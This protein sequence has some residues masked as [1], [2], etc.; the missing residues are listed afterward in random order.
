[1]RILLAD[2]EFNVR[3]ALRT[4]LERQPGLEIVGE[5][6]RSG[7]LLSQ[8]K[9]TCPDLVLLDWSLRGSAA[10]DA[11]F[12]LRKVW[13]DLAVIVLSGRPEARQ[14]ALSAGADAFI[15]KTDPPEELLAAIRSVKR[16]KADKS[17]EPE[18]STRYQAMGGKAT[19]N[20]AITDDR[21]HNQTS[22]EREV[23]QMSANQV[24]RL[25]G[26]AAIISAALSL[27]AAMA[28]I[29]GIVVPVIPDLVVFML[30]VVNNAFIL[31]A[32]IGFYG[33]QHKESG[34]LGLAGFILAMCG[35]LLDLVFAP[36][37]WLLFLAGLS[38]FAIANQRTG[39][40]PAWG[41]WLWLLGALVAILGGVLSVSMIF[42]L[43]LMTAAGGR[44]WL[45]SALWSEKTGATVPAS[46]FE[47]A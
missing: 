31:F 22:R 5:V 44:A 21:A 17:V 47:H 19:M 27:L 35:V 2:E 24:F 12:A 26:L 13:A 45:G 7:E 41:V 3:F 6:D 8:V 16:V 38:L 46:H 36:L 33:I 28:S 18:P 30:L 4:L 1:M 34:G 40:L 42:A 25:S 43:G 37:G 10:A 29:V 39:A 15:S 23:P 11:L 32:L 14:A 9:T 20:R